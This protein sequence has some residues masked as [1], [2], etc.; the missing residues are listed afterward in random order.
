MIGGDCGFGDKRTGASCM[1]I[2]DK[3]NLNNKKVLSIGD[4]PVDNEMAINSK[5]KCSILVESGQVPINE[6]LKNTKNCVRSLSEIKI[7]RIL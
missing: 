5:L 1:F 7:E 6:L 4:A 3:F 2:C